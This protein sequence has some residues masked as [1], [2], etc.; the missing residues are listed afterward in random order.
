MEHYDPQQ[1]KQAGHRRIMNKDSCEKTKNILRSS[2]TFLILSKMYNGFRLSQIAEQVGVKPQAVHYHTDRMIE[3]NLIHKYK[4]AKGRIKWKVEEKGL[5]ILKQKATGSA[6][7][8]TNYQTKLAARL[9]PTRLDNLSFM[10]KILSSIPNNNHLRWIK[11]NNNTFKCSLKYKTHTMELIKSETELKDGS[12]FMI[13]HL[14]KTYCTDYFKEL[15]NRYNFAIQFA[16][17]AAI[18]FSIEILDHGRLIKRP[19]I[20]F[21]QDLIAHYLTASQ[22]A[23]INT[24]EERPELEG[25]DEDLKAW[26]DSSGGS[27][28]FETNNLDYA[29]L[30]LLM[31]KT[32]N[33]IAGQLRYISNFVGYHPLY[34]GNN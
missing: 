20:A 29:Y 15:V 12:S 3:A 8:F 16:R 4:D 2:F 6:N 22:T 1:D 21:E 34:A 26:I 5:L 19:H 31:P 30:Y 23:E 33:E 11:I 9:I 27:G 7:S 14:E 28:E 13:I 17:Q 24:Q 10:F 32:V 18:Q 25:I